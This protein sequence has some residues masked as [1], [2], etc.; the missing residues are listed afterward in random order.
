MNWNIRDVAGEL[1]GVAD[2]ASSSHFQLVGCDA[3]ANA[4]LALLAG[5]RT[6]LVLTPNALTRR[7]LSSS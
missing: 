5:K 3:N 6:R 1:G 7:D 2:V 4:R